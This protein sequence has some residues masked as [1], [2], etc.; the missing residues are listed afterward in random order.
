MK[1]IITSAFIA[2]LFVSSS[3]AVTTAGTAAYDSTYATVTVGNPQQ[4]W[5][6]G[7]TNC[8][9]M[10]FR[11]NPLNSAPVQVGQSA[12]VGGALLYAGGETSVVEL[13]LLGNKKYDATSFYAKSSS[14]SQKINADCV[15]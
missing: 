13:P 7:P 3:F 10:R 12:T 6:A 2:L 1:K 14:G 4:I 9:I 11:A 15:R 5:S 8:A